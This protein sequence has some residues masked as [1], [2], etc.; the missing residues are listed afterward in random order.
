MNHWLE[1]ID[2]W[3]RVSLGQGD[4]SFFNSLGSFVFPPKVLNVYIVI[5]R[6]MHKQIFR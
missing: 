3:H 4:S 5:Y 6:E 2:I 1:C